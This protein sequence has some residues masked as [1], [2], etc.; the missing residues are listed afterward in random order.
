MLGLD[1]NY[2]YAM[3]EYKVVNQ[4]GKKATPKLPCARA[5]PMVLCFLSLSIPRLRVFE[6]VFF[7]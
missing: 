6:Q 7:Y 5:K 4:I 3:P 1:L 2:R